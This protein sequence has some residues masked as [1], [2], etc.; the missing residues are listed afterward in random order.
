[1]SELIRPTYVPCASD[2]NAMTD[3]MV[4]IRGSLVY[5]IG[6]AEMI[7]CAGDARVLAQVLLNAAE[8]ANPSGQTLATRETPISDSCGDPIIDAVRA[9][10][11]DRSLAGQMKYGRTLARDD[12]STLD[13]IRHAQEEALDLAA[14]LERIRRDLAPEIDDGK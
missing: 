10:L 8:M 11:L 4:T 7:F 12:L 13:R 9:R 2:N 3:C 14:Y 1:M 5:L 6:H